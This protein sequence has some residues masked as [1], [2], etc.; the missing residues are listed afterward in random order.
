MNVNEGNEYYE[1]Y[2]QNGEMH[3]QE[4][5][6]TFKHEAA[7]NEQRLQT[8]TEQTEDLEIFRIAFELFDHNR[9]GHISKQD[10]ISIT[11]GYQMVCNQTPE[12]IL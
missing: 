7:Q 5:N 10:M 1:E 3:K 2:N 11:T 4:S 6:L 9:N 8:P 12:S